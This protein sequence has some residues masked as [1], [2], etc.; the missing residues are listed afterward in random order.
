M[1]KSNMGKFPGTTHGL[2]RN[3]N[4]GSRNLYPNRSGRDELTERCKMKTQVSQTIH[5][6]MRVRM[7]N[8]GAIL[9]KSRKGGNFAGFPELVDLDIDSGFGRYLMRC[10][11]AGDYG[12]KNL[13]PPPTYLKRLRK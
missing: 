10:G 6:K 3:Q 9:C 2:G 8:I 11:A 7:G 13:P 1:A 5:A 4:A 12:G